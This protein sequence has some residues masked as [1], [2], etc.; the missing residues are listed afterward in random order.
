MG[1]APGVAPLR[2]VHTSK[3]HV[4]AVD[5]EVHMLVGQKAVPESGV[6][7]STQVSI[8]DSKARA[9]LELPGLCAE[10]MQ[11]IRE[12]P[13]FNVSTG[14]DAA[15]VGLVRTLGIA[16]AAIVGAVVGAFAYRSAGPIAGLAAGLVCFGIATAAASA[17]I[18]QLRR[19]QARHELQRRDGLTALNLSIRLLDMRIAK[20]FVDHALIGRAPI[21]PG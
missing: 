7:E 21:R 3:R 9:E 4:T 11:L 16:V 13:R 12:R 1:C 17:G 20:A 19:S 6:V 18:V 10:R 8:A 14:G 15:V 5:P 2:P